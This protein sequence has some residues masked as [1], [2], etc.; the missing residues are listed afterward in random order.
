MLWL[1][2]CVAFSALASLLHDCELRGE[3]CDV[4]KEGTTDGKKR[5]L[6]KKHARTQRT[7]RGNK[8]ESERS[9][10]PRRRRWAASVWSDSSVTWFIMCGEGQQL[11]VTADTSAKKHDLCHLHE[12]VF[13]H[14]PKQT[15]AHEQEVHTYMKIIH[16]IYLYVCI[17]IYM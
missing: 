14:C 10:G 15:A 13:Y 6:V 8:R 16:S 1:V 9:R 2:K 12:T 3:E 17:N 5:N 11:E 4:H 7:K